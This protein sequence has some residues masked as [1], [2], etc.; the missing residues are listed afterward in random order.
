MANAQADHFPFESSHSVSNISGP[1]KK[2]SDVPA[3]IATTGYCSCF[4][5]RPLDSAHPTNNIATRF[6]PIEYYFDAGIKNHCS[7]PWAG[8]DPLCPETCTEDIFL[9]M[10]VFLFFERV[11]WVELRLRKLRQE[12]GEVLEIC[13]LFLPRVES[14][15]GTCLGCEGRCV[16]YSGN[17]LTRYWGVGFE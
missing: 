13:P 7:L 11:H 4:L 10:S 6:T 9:Y 15:L 2:F 8:P 12:T 14:P 3:C 5:I 17:L 16:I 1:W